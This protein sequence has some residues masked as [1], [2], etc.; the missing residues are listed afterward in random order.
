MKPTQFISKPKSEEPG[1]PTTPPTKIGKH[2]FSQ[3]FAL[4]I[5]VGRCEYEP[6]SLPV[7][8]KDAEALKR[9]L[10]NHQN[11]GYLKDH[12]QLLT[13]EDATRREIL[14]ALEKLDSQA[15][16]QPDSTVVVYYSGHG[17]LDEEG[18]YY[19][20]P[21]DTKPFDMAHSALRAEDFTAALSRIRPERLLVILDTCH[22]AG[23]A[24]AKDAIPPGFRR[25]APPQEIA[26]ILSSGQGRAVLCSCR[27][28]QKSWILTDNNLSV[29][30]HHL[31]EGFRGQGSP[32]D[33]E[34][35]SVLDLMNHVS[36][37]VNRTAQLQNQEQDPF[38][39]MEGESFPV[40]LYQGGYGSA[41]ATDATTSHEPRPGLHQSVAITGDIGNKATV[42]NDFV[43][44][45]VSSNQTR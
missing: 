9:V 14:D 13:D 42:G 40:A 8:S 17:W 36:R 24:E 23:M 18:H 45:S 43:V 15:A 41:E 21:S 11:C 31:I 19:L 10:T 44:G 27:G 3:G 4:V 30:T 28:E 7:T 26:R 39:K 35:V 1:S 32:P 16:L 20:V 37:E 33:V 12:I 22:A 2:L 25:Q 5:G 38:H 6:W 34:Y 29:F